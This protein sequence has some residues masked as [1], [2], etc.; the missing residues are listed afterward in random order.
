MK[1]AVIGGTGLIAAMVVAELGEYGHETVA[2][3]PDS[4]NG[5]RPA[6]VVEGAAVVVDVS[7]SPS[8]P[9]LER[10]AKA[11]VG[12]YV[13]LSVVGADQLSESGY[14]RAKLAQERLVRAS[15]QAYS[16][17][18]ATEFFESI[19][20]VGTV[21]DEVRLPSALVQP[22]AAED[23]A[24]GLGRVATGAPENG[25]CEIAGP[26]QFRLAEVVRKGLAAAGDRRTVVTDDRATYHGARLSER[27]LLPGPD[28]RLGA[29]TFAEWLMRPRGVTHHGG[30]LS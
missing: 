28:A 29:I 6:E 14:F 9:L 18:R 8:A 13:V 3:A 11:G 16:I 26:E 19:A 1:I 23:V 17:V 27:V 12:H 24:A 25:T 22:M 15:G 7:D 20:E 2:A 5:H 4:L 10:S 21:G 30:A